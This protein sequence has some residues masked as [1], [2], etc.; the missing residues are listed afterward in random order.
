MVPS[1]HAIIELLIQ[2]FQRHELCGHR[3]SEGLLFAMGA[4]S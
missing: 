1:G 4:G 2:M 3:H